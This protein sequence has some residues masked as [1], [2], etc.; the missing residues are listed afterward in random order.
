VPDV[1][2]GGR[3]GTYNVFENRPIFWSLGT[4][5]QYYLLI[6]LIFPLLVSSNRLIRLTLMLALLLP[7]FFTPKTSLIFMWLP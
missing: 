5:F 7:A 6:G 1:A 2:G 4:E 3:C